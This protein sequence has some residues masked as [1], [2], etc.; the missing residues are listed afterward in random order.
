MAFLTPKSALMRNNCQ[1]ISLD[2]KIETFLFLFKVFR[3]LRSNLCFDLQRRRLGASPNW[4]TYFEFQPVGAIIRWCCGHF[5]FCRGLDQYRIQRNAP[6]DVAEAA[7]GRSH[8]Y[9]PFCES[10]CVF[11]P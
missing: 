4:G 3:S 10:L 1:K 7:R 2:K 8:S 11:Q 9:N 6:D 5:L